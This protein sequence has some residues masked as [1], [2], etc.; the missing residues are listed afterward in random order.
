MAEYDS[1]R[2]ATLR[3][4]D[5]FANTLLP[6]VRE[7][8]ASMLASG[9]HVDLYVITH[10]P[11]SPQRRQQLLTSVKLASFISLHTVG[12]QY[13]SDATPLGYSLEHSRLRVMNVTRGLAR[14]HRYVIKDKFRY[15]DLFV[16]FEDDMLIKGPHILSFNSITQE[17]YRLRRQAAAGDSRVDA[18]SSTP[19]NA[20][21]TFTLLH[22]QHYHGSMNQIQLMRMIPGFMRVEAALPGWKP[23]H[24]SPTSSF[25]ATLSSSYEN[26]SSIDLNASVCCHIPSLTTSS[27]SSSLDTNAWSDHIPPQPPNSTDLYYW[28]TAIEALSVRRMPASSW[29]RWVVLQAGNLEDLVDPSHHR[30]HGYWSGRHGLLSPE[31]KPA[32]IQGDYANNQ[33]GWMGTRRQVYEWHTR[34]CQQD[35]FVPPFA[36]SSG[37]DGLATRTVEFWSGG[38]QLVGMYACNLQRILPLEPSLFS[39]HLLYHTSNNKQRHAIV[40]RRFSSQSIQHL[41]GQLNT[42]R[43]NAQRDIVLQRRR[44]RLH[45]TI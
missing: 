34:W 13:W 8:L 33:G 35:G 39:R 5:R 4:Y 1:G 12:V 22:N 26:I 29:L 11:L 36:A 7:G 2:R 9:L 37:G 16:A 21:E 30:I 18:H 3:G 45:M 27:S 40:Q 38:L 28:E 23:R 14:Q 15:Y 25:P 10:Y 44:R 31:Q 6:V 20:N 19:L 17:L 42:V 32:A 24:K 41:W 43:V